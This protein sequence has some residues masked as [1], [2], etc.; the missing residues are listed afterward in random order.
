[1]RQHS[2][3]KCES[4]NSE[5]RHDSNSI[6]EIAPDADKAAPTFIGK[7]SAMLLDLRANEYIFWSSCGESIV[8]PDPGQ[9]SYHVL[10][11]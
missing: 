6:L 9:F 2:K 4:E 8:I 11:L 10:P 5:M 1:M 3:K 7:L